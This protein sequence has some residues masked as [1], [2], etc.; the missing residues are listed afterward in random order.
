MGTKEE[1]VEL[2]AVIASNDWDEKSMVQYK[3]WSITQFQGTAFD[4]D[5]KCY[6]LL[7]KEWPR[8]GLAVLSPRIIRAYVAKITNET[9]DRALQ[10]LDKEGFSVPR[11][12]AVLRSNQ[13]KI[14]IFMELLSGNELYSNSDHNAWKDAAK[15]LAEIHNRFWVGKHKD[16]QRLNA[17]PVNRAVLERIQNAT[18]N[19]AGKE[20]WYKYMQTVHGR[21]AEAPK[22]LIHG[23]LFPT[24]VV[25][26]NGRASFIDWAN[27]GVF[28]YMMD[29]GRLTAIIDQK[30]LLPMCPCEDVVLMEYYRVTQ[31]VLQISYDEFLADVHMAQFIELANYYTPWGYFGVNDA[32]NQ[33]SAK[34]LDEIVAAHH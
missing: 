2:A 26:D 27:A 11:M 28:A 8:N 6:K 3:N 19:A 5:Y 10:I 24:N 15:K 1:L 20:S 34:K 22:T 31:D 21:L 32:Y 17:L 30:T 23:D 9:E 18:K 13:G 14:M 12:E 33:L 7:W 29:L 16:D 25:V 4:S